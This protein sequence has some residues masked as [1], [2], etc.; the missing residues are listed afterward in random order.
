MEKQSFEQMMNELEKLVSALE[1]G[2]TELE[3]ALA[4]YKKGIGIIEI[5]SGKLDKAR[6]QIETVGANRE[7]AESE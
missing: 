4:M 7:V 2:D 3:K 6:K 5:L 1:S